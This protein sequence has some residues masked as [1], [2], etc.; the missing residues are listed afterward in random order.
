MRFPSLTATLKYLLA[1]GEALTAIDMKP[2]DFTGKTIFE[3]LEPE[4]I[5]TFKSFYEKTFAGESF[6]FEHNIKDNKYLTRGTPL[7]GEDG[8]VYA[9]LAVSYD[10]SDLKKAE[11]KLRES[12]EWLS[13]ILKSVED[14]AI[15][16]TDVNGIIN[17]WNPGAEKIFGYTEQEMI[18][19]SADII[20]TPEERENGIPAKEM[21]K[22]LETGKAPKTNGCTFAKTVRCFTLPV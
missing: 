5:E 11:E 14:Y 8:E 12:E 19:K 20:F 13:L 15:I 1:D 3:A 6:T 17:G 16:T 4:D 21:Q 18:G 9:A 10:I 22:A 7:I 2:E